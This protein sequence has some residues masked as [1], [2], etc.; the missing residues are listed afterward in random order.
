[1]LRLLIVDDEPDIADG[2]YTLLEERFPFE[3]ELYKAYSGKTALEWIRRG[4]FDIVLT[5]IRMPVLSGL[6]LHKHIRR[7]WPR[8]KVVFLTGH[9][10]FDYVYEAIQYDNT[11][12]LL[13][14]EGHE[15]IMETIGKLT[16]DIAGERQIEGLMAKAMQQMEQSLPLLQ[17]ELLS[18][19]LHGEA[20]VMPDLAGQFE[21][22][23][24]PLDPRR[25]VLLMM[26]KLMASDRGA[27]KAG[28]TQLHAGMKAIED[29]YGYSRLLMRYIFVGKDTIA[30]FVQPP[31]SNPDEQPE[32]PAMWSD[33]QLAVRDYAENA[34]GVFLRSFD[35]SLFCLLDRSPCEWE[36]I[37]DR[38]AMLEHECNRQAGDRN[39]LVQVEFDETELYRAKMLRKSDLMG[40]YLAAGQEEALDA[41][42]KHFTAEPVRIESV[43]AALSL[44]FL[45][46]IHRFN[47]HER[48][49]AHIDLSPLL[50]PS[51][52]P[53]DSASLIGYYSRLAQT[54]FEL[55]RQDQTER[56]DRTIDL[57]KGY[58]R[59]H[60]GDDLSLMRLSEVAEWNPSYLSRAF[61]KATGTNVLAYIH[62]TK[63]KEA[64]RLLLQPD[65]KIHEIS[66]TLGFISPPHF[67][68]FFKKASGFTPQDYRARGE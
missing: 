27:W 31:A 22:L 64:M 39:G 35:I 13:K 45:R 37:A 9:S 56:R 48:L 42:W 24:M 32:E 2:L 20:D 23:R 29:Q 43:Y 18:E 7:L 15:T 66:A 63:L 61:K 14:T 8:C 40:D 12:Y 16:E 49:S 68:R 57:L 3:L 54:I 1:M 19:L 50:Q 60:L 67:T 25:P 53:L 51:G 28:K 6:E 5:D 55:Q 46:H 17:N 10:E 36:D 62:E 58:I 59:D 34:E 11:S 33:I 41:E 38:W 52:L 65:M 26:A 47:L 21:E 30:W 44:V 4:K